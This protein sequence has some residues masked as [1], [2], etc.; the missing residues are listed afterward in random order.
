MG[1]GADVAKEAADIIILDDNFA[2][3]T[4]AA[5]YGRT[6]FKSIRKFIVHQSTIN[7]AS[8]IIVFLGPFLGFDFPLTLIQLLWV[9]LVM[10]TLAA[11]A[12]GGE[13]PL[14]RYMT[15]KPIERKASI[16]NPYMWT[17]IIANGLYIAL[18]S[19]IFL[20]NDSIA[21]LFVRDG[22]PDDDVFLTAFFCFFIFITNINAFNVRTTSTNLLDHLWE[23]KN[24]VFVEMFIFIVQIIFTYVG[25]SWLRTVSLTMFEWMVVTLLAVTIIPFDMFRKKFIVPRVERQLRTYLAR[26]VDTIAGDLV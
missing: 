19:I 18:L 11:L 26:N 15:E 2:S 20:T 6:I 24:F 16:I 12:F 22:V 25:G 13:P 21:E 23:N 5:L 17:A 7:L 3:V 14:S 8:M 9:N 4:K 1:S 10:D